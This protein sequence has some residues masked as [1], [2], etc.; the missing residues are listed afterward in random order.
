MFQKEVGSVC[1]RFYYN[2]HTRNSKGTDEAD[3]RV[4]EECLQRGRC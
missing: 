1:E 3:N 4:K 2:A